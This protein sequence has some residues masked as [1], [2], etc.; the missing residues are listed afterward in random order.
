MINAPE[1]SLG[2]RAGAPQSR[3]R[4]CAYL[5]LARARE[6]NS[7]LVQRRRGNRHRYTDSCSNNRG[8]G[9]RCRHEVVGLLMELCPL[10]SVHSP[11]GARQRS[12]ANIHECGGNEQNTFDLTECVYIQPVHYD[13]FPNA[14]AHSDA[15][16]AAAAAAA[17]G[18][19]AGCACMN[20]ANR[21]RF[22]SCSAARSSAAARR[23]CVRAHT[24]S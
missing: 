14:G 5:W 3:S 8:A 22:A 17:A 11:L 4:D 1:G 12:A 15:P 19:A 18:G 16:A 2:C 24:R 13:E 6:R 21:A 20:V 7:V 9:A 10:A 23:R